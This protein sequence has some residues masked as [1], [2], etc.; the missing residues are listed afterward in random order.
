MAF[1]PSETKIKK[2]QFFHINHNVKGTAVRKNEQKNKKQ[3][4][5]VSRSLYRVRIPG[6]RDRAHPPTE[7]PNER[8]VIFFIL[9]LFFLILKVLR[10]C[11]H[12]SQPCT[13][14]NLR[15]YYCIQKRL[16]CI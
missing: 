14:E 3:K 2:V 16:K 6:T 8:R 15:F 9:L 10:L 7:I 4:K 11:V 1:F 5:K 12:N 13:L